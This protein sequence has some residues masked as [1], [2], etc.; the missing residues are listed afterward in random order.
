MSYGNLR[1]RATALSAFVAWNPSVIVR[2]D[3][4]ATQFGSRLA[5]I[6]FATVVLRGL[7]CGSDFFGTIQTALVALGAFYVLGLF[8]GETARRLVEENVKADL[9]R[10]LGSASGARLPAQHA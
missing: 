1:S 10:Q 9:K 8:V 3:N 5:L 2:V 6:A 7:F 4:V